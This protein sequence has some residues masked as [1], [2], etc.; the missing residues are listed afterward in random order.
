MAHFSTKWRHLKW[1]A[2]GRRSDVTWSD[3]HLKQMTSLIS[4]DEQMVEAFDF[5]TLLISKLSCFY[6]EKTEQTICRPIRSQLLYRSWLLIGRPT[7]GAR[8][9][10]DWWLVGRSRRARLEPNERS[11]LTNQVST[12]RCR[13]R[14]WLVRRSKP[15][16]QKPKPKRTKRSEYS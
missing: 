8:R 15:T 6:F 5:L 10:V 16:R 2:D 14:L 9:F 12:K 11:K 7:G 4:S 3:R 13:R 1:L